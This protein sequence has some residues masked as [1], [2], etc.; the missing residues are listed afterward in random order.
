MATVFGTANPDFLS[1]AAGVTENADTISGLAGN[2][3]LLGGAASDMLLG[4]AGRPKL[5]TA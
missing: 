5:G 2:D 4:G 1:A 3:T